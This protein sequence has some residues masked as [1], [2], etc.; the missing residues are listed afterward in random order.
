MQIL[1]LKNKRLLKK[2]HSWLGLISG[3]IV[4][5]IAFTGSIYAFEFEIREWYYRT[6]IDLSD[7]FGTNK[8]LPPSKL[9]EIGQNFDD[10]KTIHAVRLYSDNKPSE[11]IYYSNLKENQH[12]GR[13][14]INPY[15]GKII[16]YIDLKT[17]FFPWIL[18]GH[19]YLWLPEEIGRAVVGYFTV[20]FIFTALIGLILWMPKQMK[21]L[22]NCLT[23]QWKSDTK[24]KRKNADLHRILGFYVLIP[25]MIFGV[26]GLFWSFDGFGVAYYRFWGGNKPIY[27]EPKSSSKEFNTIQL[28]LAFQKKFHCLIPSGYIDFHAPPELG[29]SFEVAW[30]PNLGNYFNTKY[31]FFDTGNKIEHKVN[32]VYGSSENMAFAD[33]LIKGN[34]DI[35]TGGILG[36]PGKILVFL[37]SIIIAGLP[38]TGLLYF[39]GRKKW[40]R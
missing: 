19:M 6:E 5:I 40:L 12:Y 4:F 15:T 33:F 3:L 14:L 38:I 32:S 18:K 27:I 36:I 31:Y 28:D 30:N 39:L 8:K 16:Q 13:L 35:H 10:S 29:K 24:W 2:L 26:T 17:G 20:I 34:Y 25:I 1:K 21:S 23:F 22:K 9:W 11:V 7:N 37:V